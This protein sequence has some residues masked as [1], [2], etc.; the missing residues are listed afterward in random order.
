MNA[1]HTVGLTVLT[2]VAPILGLVAFVLVLIGCI[3]IGVMVRAR[4]KSATL[5]DLSSYIDTVAQQCVDAAAAQVRDL[6]NPLVPGPQWNAAEAQALS[7]KVVAQITL[8]CGR[9]MWELLKLSR[10]AV[11]VEKFA[12][13]VLESA[14]ERARVRAQVA[15][16][17]ALVAQ[18]A[19]PATPP[20][21]PPPPAP[22][23][24]APAKVER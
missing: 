4:L 2:A 17:A 10:S 9:E 16:A 18:V 3:R 21:A 6:K 23:P 19:T 15:A 13:S 14:V 22:G 12:H 1:L 8:I 11:S 24:D 7:A 20:P 5:R